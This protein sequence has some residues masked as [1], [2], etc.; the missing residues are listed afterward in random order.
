MLLWSRIMSAKQRWMPPIKRDSR[1]A[2][3]PTKINAA[4]IK[5]A[6][7]RPRPPINHFNRSGG[8][9]TNGESFPGVLLWQAMFVPKGGRTSFML[10]PPCQG[11]K[12]CAGTSHAKSKRV[13][14]G[15]GRGGGRAEKSG[16]AQAWL[17]RRNFQWSLLWL[18]NWAHITSCN[19]TKMT[20]ATAR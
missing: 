9:S 1:D 11:A 18:C 13:E 10:G 8:T 15:S 17:R 20:L 4:I 7:S 3:P 2:R 14:G 19:I 5:P 6:P 16:C 12:R